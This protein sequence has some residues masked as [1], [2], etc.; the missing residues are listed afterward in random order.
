MTDRSGERSQRR[1]ASA[2]RF[3]SLLLLLLL[4]PED[5]RVEVTSSG[6]L[7]QTRAAATGKARSPTVDRR[8]RL[9]ISGE[10]ELERDR[11]IVSVWLCRLWRHGRVERSRKQYI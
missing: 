9:T 10:D 8:V 7:F 3:A 11:V 5:S 1:E 2:D 4:L 6:R